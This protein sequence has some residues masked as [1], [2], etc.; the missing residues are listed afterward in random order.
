MQDEEFN[1]LGLQLAIVPRQ[2]RWPKPEVLH[3]IK[4]HEAAN[5][6]RAHVIKFYTLADEIDCKADLSRD[7]KYHERGEIAAQAIAD[8]EASKTLARACEAVE[9]AVAKRNWEGHDS[10]EIAKDSEDMLR[11]LKDV[12]RGWQRAID[13]IAERAGLSKSPGIR[14]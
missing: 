4:L 10:P 1:A 14:R 11:A 13:K 5:E 2:P 8:F 12:E 3:W 9:L 7:G 6:A